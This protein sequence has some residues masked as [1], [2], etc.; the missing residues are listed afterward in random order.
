MPSLL[1][2]AAGCGGQQKTK[3]LVWEEAITGC[4]QFLTEPSDMPALE[5]A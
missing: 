1:G 2:E 3:R 5:E 4:Q